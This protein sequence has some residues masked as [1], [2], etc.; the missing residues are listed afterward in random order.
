MKIREIPWFDR[1]WTRLK[2]KG[3][4][5]LSKNAVDLSHRVLSKYHFHKLVDLSLP[6]LENE[7]KNDIQAMKI[8]AMFEIFRRTNRLQKKGYKPKIETAKDVFNYYVDELRDKKKE[9]FYALFLDT[10]NRIIDK[11]LISVGTLNA[12]LIH[13]REVFKS[14]IKASSNA[15]IL[16]HNHPSGD[17]EPSKEDK[18]VTKTLFDAGDILG[19]KVLDHVV[20]GKDGF[21]SLKEE[22]VL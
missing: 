1:P 6:E 3:V 10:K 20:V 7:F 5:N 13:P 21:T 18:D 22:G 16:V 17:C 11:E 4:S 2:N 14:A 9:H 12:S 15:I 19:I 8:Q